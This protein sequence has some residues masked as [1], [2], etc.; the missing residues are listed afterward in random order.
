MKGAVLNHLESRW[1]GSGP[2]SR[3][4]DAYRHW[5]V[6]EAGDGTLWISLDVV[7]ADANTLSAP[8]LEELDAL[9]DSLEGRSPRGLVLRSTKASG[10]A[11]G[12]DIEEFADADSA[13]A[14][15]RRLERAHQVVDRLEAL[16]VP[17]VA[18]VHGHCLGGGL[19][20]ALACRYRIAVAP[21]SLG[22][23]EVRLG[24]HPGL[25]GTVRSI[26]AMGPLDAMK[27]M[28]RGNSIDARKARELGLVDIVTEERHVAS[29]VNAAIAGDIEPA[30]RGIGDAA[31]STEPGR[32]IAAS[33]MR[34]TTA[35][36]VNE[37]HYPAPFALI[38]LWLDNGGDEKAMKRAE[39]ASFSHLLVSDT[40][41]NLTRVFFLN[42]MLKRL[43]GAG[44]APRHVHVIGAGTMGADIA[45]WCAI[46]GMTATLADRDPTALAGAMRSAV[47]HIDDHVKSSSEA[48]DARDRFI[49][50]FRGDGVAIADLVIEA[51][52]EDVEIKR[53]VYQDAERR[54]KAGALL[55]SNTSS[56]PIA[57]LSD[58]LSRPESFLGLHF[59]NPVPKMML[60]EVV[61]HDAVAQ[62]SL[63]TANAFTTAIGKLPV[64]VHSAPG[65]LVNRALMPYLLEAMRMLDEGIAAETID[66]AA[67]AFGMPMG[68]AELAD[69]VGLD[70]C[71]HVAEVLREGLDRELPKVPDS[72]R[73]RVEQGRLGRKAG[74]GIYDYE[75]GKPQKSGNVFASGEAMID[76]LVLPMIDACVACLRTGVA[77][78]PDHID[79][80]MVF[81]A[82]FAPFRG[83]PLH[84]ARARGIEAVVAR[85]REL[86]TQHGEHLAPDEGWSAMED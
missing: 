69:R 48:R 50:D 14:V 26:R 72:L 47:S 78:E 45:A 24:L 63:D 84:Y 81:G 23:P 64:P 33:R 60:V 74:A 43:G 39:I 67:E 40:A 61:H 53:A 71:L 57:T 68:P 42:Q 27:L 25:G 65:F 29:A 6:A 9:L 46:K 70:I 18:V 15:A 7:D 1:R 83:G 30:E 10:F 54:M 73:E 11:A 12:A 76:R 34:S 19:E 58:G 8:V 36:K 5:Q 2:A 21:A 20:L 49:P 22:F 41:R 77:A 66:H 44:D 52:P 35:E 82:G 62:S 79:A 86:A 13:D 85:L 31:I 32:R 4:D 80:A 38:E 17:T 3:S 16:D 37:E 75:D 56:I 51:V 59:F 55:A 28:L